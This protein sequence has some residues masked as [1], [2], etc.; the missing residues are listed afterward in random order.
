VKGSTSTNED[1]NAIDLATREKPGWGKIRV[2]KK[3]VPVL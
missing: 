2:C 1:H 3:V